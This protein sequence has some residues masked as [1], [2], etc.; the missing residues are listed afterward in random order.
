MTRV[1]RF[2][3]RSLA[4]IVAFPIIQSSAQAIVINNTAGVQTARDLGA[5]F[6]AVTE[7]SVGGGLCTGSLISQFYVLT[8]QHCIFNTNPSNVSVLFRD[9]DSFNT[10]LDEISVTRIFDDSSNRLLD[11]TDVAVLELSN[12]AP[13][14]ITPLRLLSN[15]NNLSGS[16]VTTVG[17]GLNGVGSTGHQFTRDGRRWAAQNTIDLVGPAAD[18][19]GRIVGGSSN[20]FSTDFDSGAFASNTLSNFGSSP[21]PLTNEGTTGPGDSGGPLLVNRNNEFLIAGVLSGGTTS[22]STFGD[23]SWWTGSEQY[24]SF[25][26]L[27]GGQFVGGSRSS[28]VTAGTA[29]R[30]TSRS[31]SDR[32]DDSP[33]SIPEPTSP[34]ALMLLGAIGA[35]IVQMRRNRLN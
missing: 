9:D 5:P 12:P 23:I 13:G 32:S 3:F 28:F 22:T 17:F 6:T 31:L 35:G 21:V 27:V 8:A 4:G 14:S 30:G 26:E 25:L 10:V 33:E 16:T 34:F 2:V 29:G 1:S 19:G 18:V 11:G 24:R 20:I 15:T 7:L